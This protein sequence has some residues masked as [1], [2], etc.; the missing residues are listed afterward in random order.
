M[1]TKDGFEPDHPLPLFLARHADELEQRGTSR[2]LKASILIIAAAALS[3][4]AI[5]LSLENPIKVFADA[6]ASLVDNL[7]LSRIANQS[8]PAIQSAA[9]APA[10]SPTP[11]GTPARD[12]IAAGPAPANQDQSANNDPPPGTLLKQFQDWA[13]KD[14]AQPQEPVQQAPDKVQVQ[15]QEPAQPVQA[16][17]AQVGEN[18]PVPEQPEHPLQ[19]HRKARSLQNA[20]AELRHVQKPKARV[21]PAPAQAPPPQD[22]RAQE[23]PQNAGPPSFLQSLG[24]HQ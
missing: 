24:L 22:P 21:Q 1:R 13:A 11:G 16:A 15:A 9:D 14:D 3:A 7:A 17:P 18:N 19:K 20:R 23:Q 8:T 2:I 10:S 5:T 12:E 4:L 6:T